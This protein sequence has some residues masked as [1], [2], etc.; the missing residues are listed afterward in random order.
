MSL[1]A[2]LALLIAHKGKKSSEKKK[3]RAE[4]KTGAELVPI[5][6]QVNT[7]RQE[8]TEVAQRASDSEVVAHQSNSR[9]FLCNSQNSHNSPYYS[10]EP[11]ASG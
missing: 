10:Y 5:K 8:K 3:C 7:A 1:L 2:L 11:N 6:G 9:R 4:R